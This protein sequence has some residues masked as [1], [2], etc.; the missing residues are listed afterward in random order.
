MFRFNNG[1]GGG[2]DKKSRGKKGASMGGGAKKASAT[3]TKVKKKPRTQ[4]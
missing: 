2:R 4:K 3:G 1:Q